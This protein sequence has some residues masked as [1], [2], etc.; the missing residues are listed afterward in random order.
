MLNLKLGININSFGY[1]FINYILETMK[2]FSDNTNYSN[3]RGI[4]KTQNYEK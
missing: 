3:K 2:K 1:L 4:N